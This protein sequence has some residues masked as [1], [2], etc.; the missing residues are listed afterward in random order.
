MTDA[1]IHRL[2]ADW[3]QSRTYSVDMLE[4]T[5]AAMRTLNARRLMNGL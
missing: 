1:E 4:R 3:L 5:R 2:L